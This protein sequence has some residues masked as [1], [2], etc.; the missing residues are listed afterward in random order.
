MAVN[1]EDEH[2]HSGGNQSAAPDIMV[3]WG[4][5]T[6]LSE[7]LTRNRALAGTLRSQITELNVRSCNTAVLAATIVPEHT[8]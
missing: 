7:Q 6:E 3:L 1:M 2:H 5:V 8:S 4:L